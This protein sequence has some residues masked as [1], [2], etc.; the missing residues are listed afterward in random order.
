VVAKFD[1]LAETAEANN[2]PRAAWAACLVQHVVHD[3]SDYRVVDGAKTGGTDGCINYS[4][5]PSL[6]T[7]LAASE[8]LAVYQ[9]HCTTVSI[10]DFLVIAAEAVMGR[11]SEN[12]DAADPFQEFSVPALFMENFKY[13]RTTAAT[14]DTTAG[15]MHDPEEGCDGLD[16]VYVDNVFQ[17]NDRAW[18]FTAALMG[19]HTLGDVSIG[20]DG[21][22]GFWGSS[23]EAATFN[24]DYFKS[25]V[26]KG[27]SAQ[28]S[29][30]DDNT[31]NQ[32]K[33]IDRARSETHKEAML[34]SDLCLAYQA[35]SDLA[36]SECRGRDCEEFEETG[37]A[38]LSQTHS[39]CAWIDPM[40]FYNA[41]NDIYPMNQGFDFCGSAWTPRWFGRHRMRPEENEDFQ[42]PREACCGGE[43][44]SSFGDCDFVE[45]NP[46]GPAIDY[47]MDFVKSENT[48]IES[49]ADAW[50]IANSNNHESLTAI[51]SED[52]ILEL[53]VPR[54][55]ANF[56]QCMYFRPWQIPGCLFRNVRSWFRDC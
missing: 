23:E 43:P 19:S 40:T 45:R 1:S 21:Y 29:V 35:N 51:G 17:G 34:S 49:F 41:E 20:Y 26:W 13:G 48:W 4:D 27:W 32:F 52:A 7:C 10:A 56:R 16:S 25:I 24:N 30:G 9:G 5:A 55:G 39:C 15:R 50:A 44:D 3:F 18:E 11:T 31:K 46:N 2:N 6:A 22:E 28:R 54:C 14:C 8:L 12:Y 33:R 42:E 36:S 37:D 53:D 47:I 38:L